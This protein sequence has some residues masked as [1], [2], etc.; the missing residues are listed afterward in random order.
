M[1]FKEMSTQLFILKTKYCLMFKV[2]QK[3]KYTTY[4]HNLNGALNVLQGIGI[5]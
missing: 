1:L 3:L 2:R 5:L 4:K